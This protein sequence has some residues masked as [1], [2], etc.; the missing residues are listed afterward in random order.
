[1][2][3]DH[4][5]ENEN[6]DEA[7]DEEDEDDNVEVEYIQENISIPKW[8]PN[9]AAF[10]QIFEAFKV[11]CSIYYH[12]KCSRSGILIDFILWLLSA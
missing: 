8:D 10:N 11:S 1:M 6:G 4:D 7:N 2:S 3:T 12:C 9:Y 5:D